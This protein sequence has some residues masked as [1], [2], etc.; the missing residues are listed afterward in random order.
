MAPALSPLVKA[1]RAG[2]SSV[3]ASSA[4][5]CPT[6]ATA[7]SRVSPAAMRTSGGSRGG[8]A[9]STPMRYVVMSAIPAVLHLDP[10]SAPACS[11]AKL[12]ISAPWI[13]A[14]PPKSPRP[15][16]AATSW[17]CCRMRSICSRSDGLSAMT[18]WR[19]PSRGRHEVGQCPQPCRTF[20]TSVVSHTV[21]GYMYLPHPA[22]AAGQ[23]LRGARHHG[24]QHLHVR[25]MTCDHCA[26]PKLEVN[27]ARSAGAY[28]PHQ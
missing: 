6:A 7:R 8:R 1:A 25:G 18:A 9:P 19:P 15:K 3:V 22:N 16:A 20:R 23:R 28:T 21:T 14:G 27:S 5:S 26:D 11:A 10:L 13:W 12:G 2:F 4:G 17:R 24:E